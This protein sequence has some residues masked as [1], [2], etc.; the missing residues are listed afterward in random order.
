MILGWISMFPGACPQMTPA[1]I[2]Y[3]PSMKIF[4]KSQANEVRARLDLFTSF[5]QGN[6]YVDEW[7]N[8]VQAQV[9]LAKYPP[10]T[11]S[12]LHWDIFWFF[13]KDEEFVPKT[14]NDSSIDLEKIPASKVRQLAKKM[15]ASKATAHHMKHIANEP[16]VAQINLMRHQCTDLPQSKSKKKQQ[17]F[18][19][20]PPSHKR[21]SGEYNQHLIPPCKKKFG[22]KQAYTR[23]DRCSKCED[24]KHV[25]GFKC[26][27]KKFQYKICNKYRYFTAC[28]T[29]NQ[30]LL[31]PE[32]PKHISYKLDRC[33]CKKIP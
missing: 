20:G 32:H 7:Y 19:S 3:G 15:E 26:P 25:E 1:W 14:I 17:S 4:C 33:T 16:Q 24:S 13:L 12:I 11:A 6:R 2:L 30:S 31:S 22:P 23:K 10:E 21:Y 9:P 5:R 27:A 29:G 18:K 28:V 8:A